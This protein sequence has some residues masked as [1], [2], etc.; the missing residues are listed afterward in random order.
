MAFFFMLYV[1]YN[2]DLHFIM[3]IKITN[4]VKTLILT[5]F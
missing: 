4:I 5:S 1:V 2:F 3:I